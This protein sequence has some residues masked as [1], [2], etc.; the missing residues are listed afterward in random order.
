MQKISLH[1]ILGIEKGEGHLIS[2]P[3]LYSFFTGASFAYFVTA[4]TSLFLNAF[5][6]NMLPPVFVVSSILVFLAGI[7]YSKF[8][9]SKP[10]DKVLRSGM[11]WLVISVAA[12]VIAFVITKSLVLIFLLYAWIR[13]YSYLSGI[14]F[15]SL[16]GR[17]FSLRQG[18]RL[19]SL[20]SSGDVFGS[21][22]SFFSVPFLLKII[23]AEEILYLS[24]IFLI[25]G[26]I[27]LLKI[28]NRFK[29]TLHTTKE[30][31]TRSEISE[32]G[33]E[34]TKRKKYYYLFY[35]ITFLPVLAQ[36]FVDFIFQSQAKIEFPEKESLTAYVGI[37]FGVSSIVEFILKTFVAGRSLSKYGLRFGL[38]AFPVVLFISFVPTIFS[39]FIPVMSLLFFAFINLGRLFT[40]AVRTAFNDPSTQ[41]LYQP[42]PPEERLKFQN[43]IESGPKAYAGIV[44]GL[45]LWGLTALPS[46][47][48]YYFCYVLL[49]II[50][51]WLKFSED[52]YIEYKK[53]LQ[54]ALQFFGKK[55]K[56][57]PE[58]LIIQVL[59]EEKLKN[60]S[61][62]KQKSATEAY[63]E[64]FPKAFFSQNKTL[65]SGVTID[66]ILDLANSPIPEKRKSAAG[67]LWLC[68]TFK[69]DTALSNLMKDDD[70]SVRRSAI[71]SAGKTRK[72]EFIPLLIRN[73]ENHEF[74]LQALASLE[75]M[76]EN[77]LTELFKLF[78]NSEGKIEMQFQIITT[79]RKIGSDNALRFIKS[80]LN[81]PDKQ[82][83]DIA[84]GTLGKMDFRVSQS[85]KALFS[86]FLETEILDYTAMTAVLIDLNRDL[87]NS[88][89]LKRI[90]NSQK[91][92]K[93]KI[94][95]LLSVMYDTTAMQLIKENLES[96]DKTAQNF[97]IEVADTVVDEKHKIFVLPIFEDISNEELLKRFSEFFPFENLSL[98]ERLEEI[99][100]ADCDKFDV[101]TKTEAINILSD[102]KSENTFRL[103][104][105]QIIN[106][107]SLIREA[108][109]LALFHKY[110]DKF[111]D[112]MVKLGRKIP[113]AKL[114]NS[115]LL[116]SNRGQNLM[117]IEKIKLLKNIDFFSNIDDDNLYELAVN[118]YES[119]HDTGEIIKT[120]NDIIYLVFSGILTKTSDNTISEAGQLLN[121]LP[122]N[123]ANYQVSFKSMLINIKRIYFNK[124][125]NTNPKIAKKIIQY[126]N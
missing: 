79:I 57:L 102:F 121:V 40:R 11:G 21:I 97:A 122:E 67:I 4:S 68:K 124:I 103:L 109:A 45:I 64:V 27:V 106:P 112:Q 115:K 48:L 53:I 94:F 17:I 18:K 56:Q 19:F 77:A 31:K 8:Q 15:W 100:N 101:A 14:S 59:F 66:E 75:N 36:F 55:E 74:R 96:K 69:A 107:N 24:I 1:K 73:V 12:I 92:K 104:N 30:E 22:L 9:N 93:Q 83:K 54:S 72:P 62:E 29:T 85:D 60:L 116:V 23:T 2:L 44:A 119:V 87:P 117:D 34:E 111:F 86:Q 7:V 120:D 113:D 6:R 78:L 49:I 20:I 108:A 89:L 39:S 16:A 13:I 25:P 5:D 80:L 114:L 95:A 71:L 110:P 32:A 91:R 65:E 98:D 10:L 88:E 47:S 3:L 46:F 35:A 84:I 26:F 37:F 123:E 76:G 42:L 33:K 82:L 81:Y 58:L 118:S 61:A 28:L 63:Y 51:V 70:K 52:I 99:I 126:I 125:I 41:I 90:E 38:L 105:S 43:K 50:I